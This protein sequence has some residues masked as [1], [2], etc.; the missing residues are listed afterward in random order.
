MHLLYYGRCCTLR[1]TALLLSDLGQTT[2]GAV[3]TDLLQNCYYHHHGYCCRQPQRLH[4]WA[5]SD[6]SSTG[7]PRSLYPFFQ[8][9]NG[10]K[11]ETAQQP[12]AR[13][14]LMSS[15]PPQLHRLFPASRKSLSRVQRGG[16]NSCCTSKK[17][18]KNAKKHTDKGGGN[19]RKCSSLHL[20]SLTGSILKLQLRKESQLAV[21]IFLQK[22]WHFAQ[23]AEPEPGQG[24]GQ[25][26]DTT[27]EPASLETKVKDWDLFQP[28]KYPMSHL[29]V[30]I[31]HT[32]PNT[33]A[34][35]LLKRIDP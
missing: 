19:P 32:H 9:L 13:N 6:V 7:G 18:K 31:L 4:H 8:Q 23:R 15:K 10:Q 2:A 21:C 3:H 33:H 24:C 22:V 27:T 16:T 14:H 12:K 26:S 28:V 1:G 17:K 29:S 20:F 30:T 5:G 35:H 25:L 11:L 34:V